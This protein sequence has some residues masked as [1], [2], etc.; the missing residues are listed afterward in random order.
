MGEGESRSNGQIEWFHWFAA[1]PKEA[2]AS[3][4]SEVNRARLTQFVDSS[5]PG[6][7]FPTDL[8]P[9]QFAEAVQDLRTNESGWNRSLMTVILILKQM[10]LL[11]LRA[12]EWRQLGTGKSLSF[13]RSLQTRRRK[14]M[15]AALEF[16]DSEV[17]SV[18]CTGSTLCVRFAA[19]YV[20]QSEGRPGADAGAGYVQSVELLFHEAQWS[21]N[22]QLCFG[23]LVER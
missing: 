4:A 19:A 16:H 21:G 9:E 6:Y 23:R 22:A 17:S 7:S 1:Q 18:E 14:L 15:N 13:V 11:L 10:I 3:Q 8:S 20:H 12:S 5:L 2:I